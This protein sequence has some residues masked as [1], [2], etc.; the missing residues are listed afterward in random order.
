MALNNSIDT[1][2]GVIDSDYRGNVG[3]VTFNY[4][5]NDYEVKKGSDIAKLIIQKISL[6]NAKQV[7]SFTE[8][9]IY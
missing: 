2:A 5:N 8:Y 3:V 9:I 4:G 1:G 6:A 7:D